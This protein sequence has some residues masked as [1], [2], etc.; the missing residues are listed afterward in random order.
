MPSQWLQPTCG[1]VSYVN[2]A[3]DSAVCIF[4]ILRAGKVAVQCAS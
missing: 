1:P 2:L 3:E 4:I